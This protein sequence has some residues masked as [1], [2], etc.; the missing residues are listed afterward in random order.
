MLN[1]K[2]LFIV[3]IL[4]T[5]LYVFMEWLFFVT[6][7]AFMKGMA[8]GEKLG[9]LFVSAGLVALFFL[10]PVLILFGLSIILARFRIASVFFWVAALLTSFVLSVLLLILVDNF[11]YTVF[12]FGIVTSSGIWRG[13]YAVFLVFLLVVTTRWMHRLLGAKSGRYLQRKGMLILPIVLLGVSLGFGVWQYEPVTYQDDLQSNLLEDAPNILL[14]GSDGVSASHMSLYGYERDTTPFLE[15]LASD[16]LVAENAFPN[17]NFSNWSVAGLLTGRSPSE[18]GMT[19]YQ[20][21]MGNDAYQHLPGIL[22]S[23]GYYTAQFGVVQY[24]DADKINLQGAF[25]EVNGRP[26]LLK[27]FSVVGRALGAGNA[28]YFLSLLWDR[29]SSRLM[30]IF[31]V[32]EMPNPIEMVKQPGQFSDQEKIE[33]ALALLHNSE[34]PVFVHVHLLGTHGPT[35]SPDEQVFSAG[36]EQSEDW[37]I[38]YYDDAILSF[39]TYI[40]QVYNSLETSGE[41][42]NTIIIVYT[43]HGMAWTSKT[44][45]PLLIRFPE[46]EAARKVESNVQNIDI[47][48]TVLEYLGISRPSWMMG[49][50]FLQSDPPAGRLIVSIDKPTV[51]SM[52]LY[53]RWYDFYPS[54]KG[55]KTGEIDVPIEF[56]EESVLSHQDIP[57]EIQEYLARRGIAWQELTLSRFTNIADVSVVRRALIAPALLQGKYGYGYFP[58]D[59][60][61]IF[62]DVP[63]SDIYAPWIEQAY[64]AGIMDACAESPLLFC[65]Q[66][67]VKRGEAAMLILKAVEGINYSPAPAK[68]VFEDVPEDS[69]L[70]PWIEELYTRG[71]TAGCVQVPRKYCPEQTLVGAHLVI[72]LNRAFAQP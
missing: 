23:Y 72:F 58:P 40:E 10:V 20:I 17:Y 54:T 44:R 60:T 32:R 56:S 18:L 33:N 41:L 25:D 39:D 35:F 57:V 36:E 38:D 37:M 43:D 11:T 62:S 45:I 14:I 51:I 68:G 55:W 46:G 29:A 28:C 50:S 69:S 26:S 6:M 63:A 9:I 3:S 59:A 34:A 7:P 19:Q 42:D 65:P 48:P 4:T 61:G 71:I 12:R 27:P 24:I 15:Q 70:A 31:Y 2:K 8:F 49:V 5:Y 22:R 16:S 67:P 1:W 53:D 52:V 64:L 66:Q 13:A 47:V 30:H 21:L